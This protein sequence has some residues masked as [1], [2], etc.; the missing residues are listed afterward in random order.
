MNTLARYKA[1]PWSEAEL[2]NWSIGED[3]VQ[4]CPQCT[5]DTR[6]KDI[7]QDHTDAEHQFGAV[8]PIQGC[9]DSKIERGDN[10]DNKK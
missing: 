3:V 2:L 10:E 6:C 7:G 4:C 9:D 1:G 8:L 5:E